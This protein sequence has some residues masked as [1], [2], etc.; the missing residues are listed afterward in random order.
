MNVYKLSLGLHSGKASFQNRAGF[1]LILLESWNTAGAYSSK[2]QFVTNLLGLRSRI[3]KV[4]DRP[5]AA[6]A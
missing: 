4:R 2:P 6:K 3:P 5:Q 1:P